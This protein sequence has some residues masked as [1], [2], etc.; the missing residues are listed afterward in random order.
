MGPIIAIMVAALIIWGL[1]AAARRL[2]GE[3]AD[4]DG[5]IT[6]HP[7][8]RL[9]PSTPQPAPPR[10]IA[11][12]EMEYAD[13]YGEVTTRRVL[14]TSL[15]GTAITDAGL[16]SIERFAGHCMLRNSQ[17][18]FVLDR[19]LAL[20]TRGSAH[21]LSDDDAIGRFFLDLAQRAQASP[22]ITSTIT[23]SPR[24]APLP[25]APRLE[26]AIEP[27]DMDEFEPLARG[28][29]IACTVQHGFDDNL[30]PRAFVAAEL[31]GRRERGGLVLLRV[32]GHFP[33]DRVPRRVYASG[34]QELIPDGEV[35]PTH[36]PSGWLLWRAGLAS[37]PPAALPGGR[38]LQRLTNPITAVVEWERTR[39]DL[40]VFDV[41]IDEVEF[42]EA[43]PVSFLCRARRRASGTDRAWSGRR[44][45]RLGSY[46]SFNRSIRSLRPADAEP[47]VADPAA[48]L[49][50]AIGRPA[51]HS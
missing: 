5:P 18:N 36:D 45:F 34:I 4:Q 20:R 7:A 37:S 44:R 1:V 11:D 19:I 29:A 51:N 39:G 41:E 48:W 6:E 27:G 38:R 17:R 33:P 14:V 40:E 35:A 50:A 23:D 13:F 24:A 25:G 8:Q 22:G 12:I 15:D 31:Y 42:W 26:R 30:V 3:H 2:R 49:S 32:V 10:N 16:V 46:D 9:P 43:Q 28:L 47:A 21:W